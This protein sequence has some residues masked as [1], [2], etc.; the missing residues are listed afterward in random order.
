MW[1][2]RGRMASLAASVPGAGGRPPGTIPS[3]SI[4]ALSPRDGHLPGYPADDSR[5]HVDEPLPFAVRRVAVGQLARSTA[6]LTDRALDRD[7]AI[8]QARKAMKRLRGLLRLVR[9]EVGEAAYKAENTMLRDTARR[10]APVRDA[11]VTIDTLDELHRM[12]VGVLRKRAFSHTRTFLQARLDAAR[13]EVVG[14]AQLLTDVVVNLNAARA[15]FAAWNPLP[16]APRQSRRAAR[17]VHDGYDAIGP[18]LARVYRRGR[19]AM[20]AAYRDGT[21]ESFHELRKRVKY[22]RYQLET[23]EP[24]WPELLGAHAARLDTLGELLGRDHDLFV[25]GELVR[26]H[27]EASADQRER[28]VLLALIHRTRLELQY[29]ARPL[30][31]SLYHESPGQFRARVGAYWEA[32]RGTAP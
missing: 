20:R 14:D 1:R 25:L 30:G 24:V 28:T 26:D 3:L 21:P 23:I 8:H 6:G 2:A 19:V 27:D 13:V 15:R 12:Y 11:K 31:Q 16:D 5:L 22:L 17:G 7:E 4:A 29:E 10:L 9:D 18:G 32:A